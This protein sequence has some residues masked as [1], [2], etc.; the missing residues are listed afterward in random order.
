[1]GSGE[2]WKGSRRFVLRTLREFGFGEMKTMTKCLEEE[3]D[4]F[5]HDF[6]SIRSTS[7]NSEICMHQQFNLSSLNFLWRIMCGTRFSSE[8]KDMLQLVHLIKDTTSLIS[9]GTQP[10]FAFPFLRHIPGITVHGKICSMFQELITF[11]KVL[12]ISFCVHVCL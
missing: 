10:V 11:F 1:M 12:F 4:E 2:I 8:D 5:L 9:V 7:V 3:I 6:E